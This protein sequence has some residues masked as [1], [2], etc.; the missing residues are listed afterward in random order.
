MRL[1]TLFVAM[2]IA[3]QLSPSTIAAPH[4][5]R[6]KKIVKYRFVRKRARI[7][8]NVIED[9]RNNPRAA[10]GTKISRKI[11]SSSIYPP[12]TIITAT[13]QIKAGKRIVT[14]KRSWVVCDRGPTPVE[15]YVNKWEEQKFLRH[16]EGVGDVIVA[17]PVRRFV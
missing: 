10:N 16:Y 17:I 8:H 14:E 3:A 1:V 13:R 6:V 11:A 9:P 2:L 12:G 5:P 7:V 4:H 15:L